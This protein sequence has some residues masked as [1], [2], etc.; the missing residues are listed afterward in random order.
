MAN[1]IK[2]KCRA[3]FEVLKVLENDILHKTNLC[4]ECYS[5]IILGDINPAINNCIQR[6]IDSGLKAH[7]CHNSMTEGQRAKTKA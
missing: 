3:C 7:E 1:K 4:S 5:E 2:I 6:N